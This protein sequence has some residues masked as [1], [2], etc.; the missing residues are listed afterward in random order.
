LAM[1][2]GHGLIDPTV[3]VAQYAFTLAVYPLISLL[4]GR[5]QRAFLPAV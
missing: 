3:I 2:I 5:A 1:V 4:M